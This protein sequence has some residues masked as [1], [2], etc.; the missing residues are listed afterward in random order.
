VGTPTITFHGTLGDQGALLLALAN[1]CTCEI[2]PETGGT[3]AS[4]PGHLMLVSDQR[5][6]DGLAFERW[7]AQRL[8]V[9]EFR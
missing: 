5:A 3:R 1:H 6:L 2:D 9:E 8:L 4:C 7:Q